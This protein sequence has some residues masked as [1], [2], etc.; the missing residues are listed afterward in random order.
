MK[1]D[2]VL[3][4]IFLMK[5]SSHFLFF[6]QK[7][8]N[9][10]CKSNLLLFSKKLKN[11]KKR[12]FFRKLLLQ[13]FAPS[14]SVGQNQRTVCTNGVVLGGKFRHVFEIANEIALRTRVC[15]FY[16][17][18][19]IINELVSPSFVFVREFGL[20]FSHWY[21]LNYEPLSF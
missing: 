5:V 20:D 19:K 13:T 14:C 11:D 2:F 15:N 18:G 7:S 1:Y 17:F 16:I 21:L 10:E 3:Y 12:R 8:L 9:A 4:Y 6:W